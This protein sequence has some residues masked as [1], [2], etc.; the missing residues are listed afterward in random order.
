MNRPQIPLSPASQRFLAVTF[1]GT[2]PQ[3]SSAN[4]LLVSEVVIHLARLCVWSAVDEVVFPVHVSLFAHLAAPRP[5]P[6]TLP[7]LFCILWPLSPPI[8][9]FLLAI[10]H[11]LKEILL[12]LHQ[13]YVPLMAYLSSPLLLPAAASC[14]HCPPSSPS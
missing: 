7:L 2:F 4:V 11:F 6:F 10:T 13:L 12:T 3:T 8:Y 14:P 1:D 9:L 5:F